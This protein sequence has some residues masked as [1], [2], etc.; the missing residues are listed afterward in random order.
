MFVGIREKVAAIN[1]FVN[2]RER[3][4]QFDAGAHVVRSKTRGVA[5]LDAA[6]RDLQIIVAAPGDAG[7]F[8]LA[9]G[10]RCVLFVEQHHGARQ[11]GVTLKA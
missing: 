6:P 10:R 2:F 1:Y 9:R 3:M 8:Q 11:T 7:Q 5:A 4:Q